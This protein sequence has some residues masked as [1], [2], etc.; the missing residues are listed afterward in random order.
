MTVTAG[1]G[2]VGSGRSTSTASAVSVPGPWQVACRAAR[3]RG[4]RGARPEARAGLTECPAAELC[5]RQP[6]PSRLLLRRPRPRGTALRDRPSSADV[7]RAAP[8]PPNRQDR[9]SPAPPSRATGKT[10]RRTAPRTSHPALVARESV[11]RQ[12]TRR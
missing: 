7:P 5:T 8:R 11:P 6:Q 9:H 4:R 3:C 2:R 1:S 10:G 12:P